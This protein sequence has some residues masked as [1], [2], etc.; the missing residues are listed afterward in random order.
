M[1][2]ERKTVRDYI[3]ARGLKDK[4]FHSVSPYHGRPY[5]IEGVIS[6]KEVSVI[7]MGCDTPE[8]RTIDNCLDDVEVFPGDRGLIFYIDKKIQ[9]N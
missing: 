2:E 3:M 1:G 4:S 6:A 9:S 8:K 7:F 5:K